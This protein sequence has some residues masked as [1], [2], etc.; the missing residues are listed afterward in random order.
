MVTT[1]REGNGINTKRTTT[2]A[3]TMIP[4]QYRAPITGFFLKTSERIQENWQRIWLFSLWL[5]LNLSLFSYKFNEYTQKPTFKVMGYCVC[6]AKGA[7]ETLKLNMAL[8]L[9]PVCRRSLTRLR[10]S[11]L[12]KIFPFDDN[13]NFHKIIAMGIAVGSFAHIFFHLTCNIVRLT[14]CSPAT[15]NAIYGK[16][17]N[18]RQPTYM[19]VVSTIPGTTGILMTVLMTFSFVLALHWFRRNIIKFPWPL[20]NLGGFNSFW[21]AHHLL[22]LAYILLIF[23]GYFLIF[24][25]EWHYKTVCIYTHLFI[26]KFYVFF[27]F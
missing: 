23:H 24:S 25:T 1:S 8:I 27:V 11:L 17:F 5:F 9:L 21:Y 20:N 7:A 19:E 4:K 2:L 22:A 10:E 15:F 13:I 18:H 3:R 12:G 26:L 14:S 6:M 16:L